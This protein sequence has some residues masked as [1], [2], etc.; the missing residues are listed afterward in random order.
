M[1]QDDSKIV[2][3]SHKLSFQKLKSRHHCLCKTHK[4]QFKGK[5]FMA[6]NFN[7]CLAYSI[8]IGSYG[9]LSAGFNIPRR[10]GTLGCLCLRR[11]SYV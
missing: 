5:N 1:A 7:T 3:F 2:N 11:S 9:R 10:D 6:L 4:K 8:Q